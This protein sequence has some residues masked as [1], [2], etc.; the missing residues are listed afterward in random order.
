MYRTDRGNY[1]QPHEFNQWAWGSRFPVLIL[2][3]LKNSIS[4]G[5]NILSVFDTICDSDDCLAGFWF[6][7]SIRIFC[8][9]SSEL[10]CI[11]YLLCYTEHFRK[12]MYIPHLYVKSYVRAQTFEGQE[13]PGHRSLTETL[14]RSHHYTAPVYV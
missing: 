10:S 12:R 2:I 4:P 8:L 3:I 5:N 11:S 9:S 14:Y 13:S 6:S 7:A 1:L